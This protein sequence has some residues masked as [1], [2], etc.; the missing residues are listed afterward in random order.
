MV[1]MSDLLITKHVLSKSKALWGICNP[2]HSYKT[3]S[4]SFREIPLGKRRVFEPRRKK[5]Q[6]IKVNS[7]RVVCLCMF[8]WRVRRRFHYWGC[9]DGSGIAKGGGHGCGGVIFIMTMLPSQ[10]LK[11]RKSWEN[12]HLAPILGCRW[13]YQCQ[14]L[15]PLN[16]AVIYAFSSSP[17][18][19]LPFSSSL[20]TQSMTLSGWQLL[21]GHTRGSNFDC[22]RERLGVST[23]SGDHSVVP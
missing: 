16:S 9:Y 13:V 21:T 10:V 7:K 11:A 5:H 12:I 18:A 15:F 1:S 4:P 6:N 23:S 22:L 14:F 3:L 2:K 17:F 19:L 20:L 8:G